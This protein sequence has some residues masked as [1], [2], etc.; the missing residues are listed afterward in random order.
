MQSALSCVSV[1]AIATLLSCGKVTDPK[2]I[3]VLKLKPAMSLDA[4]PT[5]DGLYLRWQGNNAEKDFTGYNIYVSS[6]DSNT[7]IADFGLKPL[8][9][10]PS[11]FYP[12]A[13]K[14]EKEDTI[15]SVRKNM[16]KHFNWDKS[17]SATKDMGDGK[18]FS[19]FTRCGLAQSD[20]SGSECVEATEA[21]TKNK[22]SGEVFFK[23]PAGTLKPTQSYMVFVTS[24][25]DEGKKIVSPTSNVF[26]IKPQTKLSMPADLKAKSGGS[27]NSIDLSQAGTLT[28]KEFVTS[29]ENKFCTSTN[30]N[31]EG[32]FVLELVNASQTVVI[33]GINGAR[34]ADLG[35][36]FGSDGNVVQSNLLSSTLKTP[37]QLLLPKVNTG[38]STTVPLDSDI[39]IEAGYSRCGQSRTLLPFHLY[40]VAFIDSGKWRYALLE[41]GNVP[42]VNNE[43][44]EV[45]ASSWITG[46]VV[47][48]DENDRRL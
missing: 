16:A 43:G 17:S 2:D 14:D 12:I 27:L 37:E 33:S 40:S 3:S 42:S 10:D 4:V 30:S 36:V 41:T 7:V 25:L 35:P 20:I 44:N 23:F 39:G 9:S 1:A 38:V 34:I 26:K 31:T 28:V 29:S 48:K 22:S 32:D 46:V 24:T 15:E 6:S 18:T 47:G 45:D 13:F 8:P 5:E 21:N 19:P 11:Q